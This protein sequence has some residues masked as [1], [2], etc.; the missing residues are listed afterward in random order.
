MIEGND[1]FT[2]I[3]NIVPINQSAR[4]KFCI[5]DGSSTQ[6]AFVFARKVMCISG[7]NDS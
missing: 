3:E 1:L 2:Q 4:Q 5:F 7:R 6:I